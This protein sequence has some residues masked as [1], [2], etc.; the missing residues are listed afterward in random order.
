[1]K[2]EKR[3]I[4]ISKMLPFIFKPTPKEHNKKTFNFKPP[5]S[6]II[7]DIKI[8][9]TLDSLK[10]K[11]RTNIIIARRPAKVKSLDS[12]EA[13]LRTNI[14]IARH[15]GKASYIKLL[16]A[17]SPDSYLPPPPAVTVASHQLLSP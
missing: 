17:S 6:H 7:I 13:K 9:K 16:N 12:L 15:P 2:H 10:A 8:K 3:I 11:N 1:M 4:K 5:L 14:R